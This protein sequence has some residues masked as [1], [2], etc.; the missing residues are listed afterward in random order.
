MRDRISQAFMLTGT[1]ALALAPIAASAETRA[2]DGA[3]IYSPTV[4]LKSGLQRAPQGEDESL[5]GKVPLWTIAGG[6]TLLI[7]IALALG[8]GGNSRSGGF[9]SNGAN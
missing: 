4:A 9:H 5:V 3:R 1:I 8:G 2:G 7:L 6:A